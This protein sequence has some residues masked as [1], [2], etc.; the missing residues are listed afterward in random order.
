M[1][2]PDDYDSKIEKYLI[3]EDDIKSLPELSPKQFFVRKSSDPAYYTIVFGDKLPLRYHI[4]NGTFHSVLTDSQSGETI[5]P[6]EKTTFDKILSEYKK[7]ANV[8][9]L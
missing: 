6:I 1:A 4:E 5:Y 7:Y 8:E 3:N 2:L 9:N